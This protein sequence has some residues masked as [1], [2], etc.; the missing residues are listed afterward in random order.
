MSYC[1]RNWGYENFA[2]HVLLSSVRKELKLWDQDQFKQRPQLRSITINLL[3]KESN[4]SWSFFHCCDLCPPRRESPECVHY[5][6]RRRSSFKKL[7]PDGQLISHRMW[8]FEI[9]FL[10]VVAPP[11]SELSAFPRLFSQSVSESV[12]VVSLI[13]SLFLCIDL[14]AKICLALY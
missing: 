3:I 14:I 12:C 4:Y 11:L 10:S 8:I 9:E 6:S 2:D 7:S 5:S 13:V 1:T